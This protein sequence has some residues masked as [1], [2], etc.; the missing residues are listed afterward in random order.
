MTP[1]AV[2]VFGMVA[3][4]GFMIVLTGKN[5]VLRKAYVAEAEQRRAAQLNSAK[6]LLT[7]SVAACE[8]GEITR[9]MLW[10]ARAFEVTPPEDRGTLGRIIR[11][12]LAGV[13][14][15]LR[16]LRAF[17]AHPEART[18]EPD[19]IVC[20]AAFSPDGATILTGGT[21]GTA[22]FWNAVD[23]APIG[24]PLDHPGSVQA[25]AFSR[26]GRLAVT[27]SKD[28]A[29]LWNTATAEPRGTPIPQPSPVLAAA[30]A[31]DGTC[32]VTVGAG[33]QDPALGYGNG[34][35]AEHCSNS[36]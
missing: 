7:Q 22:Q 15:Q 1:A 13:T 12:N 2:L 18:A 17:L 11:A 36:E 32:F 35:V 30:F 23:G 31:R 20:S 27:G 5:R 29:R 3:I 19:W 9:G 16:P 28:A 4:L 33:S 14:Q 6:V 26:V 8:S 10:L 24:R 21:N 34:Q 25:V